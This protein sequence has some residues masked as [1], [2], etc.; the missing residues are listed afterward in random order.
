LQG[1]KC[2]EE[3]AL[4]K[5]ELLYRIDEKET[6]GSDFVKEG[7]HVPSL[8]IP[9]SAPVIHSHGSPGRDLYYM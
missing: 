7:I 8:P 3:D 5:Q 4:I 2:Q 1:H 9:V 6:N